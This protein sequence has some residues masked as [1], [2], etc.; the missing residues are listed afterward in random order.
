M[1]REAAAAPA[2]RPACPA[3]LERP[4]S[5]APTERPACPAPPKRPVGPAPPKRLGVL[6]TLVLDTVD[7]P[8]HALAPGLWGGIAYSLAAFDHVLPP[9]WTIVPLVKLGADLAEPGRRCLRT[10]SC[11]AD[12]SR[13]RVMGER[14]NQVELRYSSSGRRTE[15]LHGGVPGWSGE[16]IAR[17]LP[18]LDALYV[19]FISG[20]E[21]DLE[22]ARRLRR[23]AAGPVYADLHSLFLGVESDG[24]R[25]PRAL[26]EAADFAACF[27]FVQMNEDEFALFQS[28]SG[29]GVSAAAHAMRGRAKLLAVTRGPGGAD[30]VQAPDG[31]ATP[32][33]TRVPPA[34][35]C[36]DGDPTGCGDAWGAAFFAR[37]LDGAP[38]SHAAADAN[39]VAAANLDCSGALAFRAALARRRPGAT[40]PPRL[41]ASAAWVADG[42]PPAAEPAPPREVRP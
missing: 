25:S 36:Q 18:P 41:D 8:G 21:L 12:L 32:E 23:V 17:L 5:L 39:A 34:R 26:P 16:E 27:D 30:L 24:R 3:P 38:P 4:A 42:P 10:L 1:T 29:S 28:S 35:S 7:R 14:N 6:G 13:I 15:R 11:S 9:G 19:N 22:A 37:L 2:E 33:T 40:R 31:I 20:M